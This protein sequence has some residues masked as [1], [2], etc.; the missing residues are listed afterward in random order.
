MAKDSAARIELCRSFHQVGTVIIMKL[1]YIKKNLPKSNISGSKK[2]S[3][4]IAHNFKL[5][6][7]LI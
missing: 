2:H 6:Y 4:V 3:K 7:I 5:Q 1:L